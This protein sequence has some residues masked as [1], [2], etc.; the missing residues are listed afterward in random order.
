MSITGMLRSS[1][2]STSKSV[3][4]PRI[5]SPLATHS[6][7]VTSGEDDSE[8]NDDDEDDSSDDDDDD[9]GGHNTNMRDSDDS[10]VELGQWLARA[11]ENARRRAA[12][13]SASAGPP[14]IAG[15]SV[16]LDDFDLAAM[17]EDEEEYATFPVLYF[18]LYG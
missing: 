4:S 6:S 12:A 7:S 2:P 10:D 18:L 1:L 13:D 5:S 16:S 3:N 9:A 17:H 14:S 15:P 8:D 11:K